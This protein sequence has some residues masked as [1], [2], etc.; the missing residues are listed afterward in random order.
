M[1]ILLTCRL[2]VQLGRAA[3]MVRRGRKLQLAHRPP[4]VRRQHCVDA[5]LRHNLRASGE[6]K[7]SDR[8]AACSELVPF[9]SGQDRRRD[10]RRQV[11]C[12]ALRRQHKTHPSRLLDDLPYAN[13]LLR[14][15]RHARARVLGSSF[16]GLRV[17]G[18]DGALD[19]PVLRLCSCCKR[20]ASY[21]ADQ[22]RRPQQPPRL[23]ETLSVEPI[24]WAD[25]LARAR[26]RS[27]ISRGRPTI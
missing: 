18:L 10:R 8:D 13:G 19:S 6:V 3:G 23:L 16:N 7:H 22:G 15:T 17:T 2:G 27:R 1:L 9:S 20:C 11:H 4:N 25:H 21:L 5:R 12:A 14:R 24:P 26:R